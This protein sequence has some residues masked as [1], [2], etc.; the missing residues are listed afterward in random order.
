MAAPIPPCG[1]R[2]PLYLSEAQATPAT[3]AVTGAS[4]FLS[5][6]LVKRLLA[7][8]HVVHG[9]ARNPADQA[10]LGHLLSL[11][12]AAERLRLFKVRRRWRLQPARS[13][14]LK[15]AQG[16]VMQQAAATQLCGSST[17][18]Q[19]FLPQADLLQPGSFD[20]AFQGCRYVVHAATPVAVQVTL[21]ACLSLCTKAGHLRIGCRQR[22]QYQAAAARR[23]SWPECS[24]HRCVAVGRPRNPVRWFPQVPKGKGRELVIDPAVRG[25]ENVLAAVQ[26]AGSVEA[27][28]MTSS[29]VA[30]MGGTN[31]EDA[32]HVFT[33]EVRGSAAGQAAMQGRA[34][35]LL[36]AL[37]G[38]GRQE[39]ADS[40]ASPARA[41]DCPRHTALRRRRPA[42]VQDWND[43]PA[44]DLE[45]L[46][47]YALAK[48]E[49]E[50]RAWELA[51]KQQPPGK[52]GAQAWR[53]AVVAPA[54]ITG[55]PD[56]ARWP[57]SRG[58]GSSTAQR[59][60]W[61]GGTAVAPACPI[62]SLLAACVPLRPPHLR[63]CS[64]L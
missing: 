30:V 42:H 49:S 35:R 46:F 26:S 45:R 52:Q 28:V 43:L 23:P 11:P 15:L 56:G 36:A 19:R 51:G 44:E 17:E 9:T 24:R 38:A 22:A 59:V 16:A 64:A 3:V 48:V 10:K 58:T 47:P 57:A 7:A 14:G 20:A 29:L 60:R 54:F 39:Q 1:L 62:G 32:A 21:P 40:T 5:S 61:P 31:L 37:P 33:E 25:V 27:V 4:G 34:G 50:K 6:A 2:V 41:G 18:P 53:L 12:G 55:P 8:G 13:C 63:P